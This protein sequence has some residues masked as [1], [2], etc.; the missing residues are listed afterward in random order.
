MSLEVSLFRRRLLVILH[1]RRLF[2]LFELFGLDPLIEIGFG[3]GV[4]I[5][6]CA[7]VETFLPPLSDAFSESV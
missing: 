4:L 2:P 3:V 5:S 7:S 1:L 6:T